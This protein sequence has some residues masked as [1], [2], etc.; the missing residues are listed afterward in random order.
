[1]A[2]K[3]IKEKLVDMKY[4]I[5][6]RFA[7]RTVTGQERFCIEIIK[8]LDNIVKNDGNEWELVVP[9]Y[10]DNVPNCKN[11]K[12][13]RKGKVKGHLWEQT[14][15]AAYVLKNKGLS[16]NM[17]MK[18]PL[19]SPGVVVIHD[20]AY[21]L[22]YSIIKGKGTLKRNVSRIW[23][24]IHHRFAVWFSPIIFTVSEYSKKQIV[25]IYHIDPDRVKV[26]GNGWQHFNS[27]V[28]DEGIFEKWP[29]LEENEYFFTLGSL[30][31]NKNVKW[32]LDVAKKNK[33]YKFVI[34]GKASLSDFG[35]EYNADTLPN[36][37]IVGYISD[38]EVKALMSKCKA[39][40][41]PSYFEGFGIPPLEAM[42]VGA[43]VIVAKASCL[44]EIYGDAAHYID[45]DNANVD[46]DKLLEEKTGDKKNILE[47]YSWNRFARIMYKDIINIR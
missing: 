3:I 14:N 43:D 22:P 27:V 16:I 36:V 35:V 10:A 23:H 28:P 15:F 18:E 11:I 37:D 24:R 4:I 25:E 19:I 40:I 26:L 44:P 31:A 30:K 46:L 7:S 39:F 32:I 34:A 17:S 12:V 33:N 41:F 6:G 21:K 42:S 47:K 8:E 29:D 20:M 1:M 38:G 9:E 2:E 13:V 45:P 5:N